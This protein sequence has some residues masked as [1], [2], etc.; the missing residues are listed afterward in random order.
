PSWPFWHLQARAARDRPGEGWASATSAALAGHTRRRAR[1]AASNA[2]SGRVLLEAHALPRH[3]HEPEP[4]EERHRL[5][6]HIDVGI[7]LLADPIGD[8][9]G[10]VDH[11]E[12]RIGPYAVPT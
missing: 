4:D 5:G 6:N 7:E 2:E 3:V 12:N 8:G 1:T 9:D 10:D 11:R